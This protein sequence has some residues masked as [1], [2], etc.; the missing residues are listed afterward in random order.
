M[1][2]ATR[3]PTTIKKMTEN[4]KCILDPDWR[5]NCYHRRYRVDPF[6]EMPGC[7]QKRKD[8]AERQQRETDPPEPCRHSRQLASPA[9]QWLAHF[10]RRPA[11]ADTNKTFAVGNAPI[12]VD[13]GR[14]RSVEFKN[15]ARR[16]VETVHHNDEIGRVRTAQLRCNVIDRRVGIDRHKLGRHRRRRNPVFNVVRRRTLDEISREPHIQSAVSP[17]K[18]RHGVTLPG[19]NFKYIRVS[20]QSH[21][22]CLTQPAPPPAPA[23]RVRPGRADVSACASAS[24]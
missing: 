6:E 24:D 7:Y 17:K 13:G 11:I 19:L 23:A 12:L 5:A 20:M 8:K 14:G 1:R 2:P 16:I 9:R 18:M 3:M 21:D 22:G 10:L 15:G 4:R